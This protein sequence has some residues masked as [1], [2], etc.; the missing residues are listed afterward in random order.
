MMVNFHYFTYKTRASQE[1]SF[2][3]NG[4]SEYPSIHIQLQTYLLHRIT[5]TTHTMSIHN[6]H[7]SSTYNIEFFTN[8]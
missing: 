7:N 8:T 5:H 6:S 2:R 1:W 3:A 4:A